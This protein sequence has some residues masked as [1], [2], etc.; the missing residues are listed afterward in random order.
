M[1]RC[2]RV[3]FCF[4]W[5]WLILVPG[6]VVAENFPTLYEDPDPELQHGLVHAVNEIGLDHAIANGNLALA[7]VD[8]TDLANPKVA[9]LNGTKMMYAAS[10]P[11]IVILFGLFKRVEEGSITYE[12]SVKSMAEQM[13]RYSS[14]WAATELFDLVQPEFLA[15]LLV[16]PK[17]Q[18]YDPAHGGGLWVGK[19]Y[20]KASAWRREPLQ[21]L[22]HAAT[23]LQT[24]RFYYLLL[25]DQLVAKELR[26][27]MES[28]LDSPGLEH[29]FVLGMKQYCPKAKLLRKS[30]SWE[31]FHSDS[32]VI[33]HNGKR[34]IA[35]GLTH[36]SNGTAWLEKLIPRLD[37][38]I[39]HVS[40]PQMG[41]NNGFF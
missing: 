34:Y 36:H 31:A 30:G 41:C 16:S 19:E 24:A 23:A 38:V 10:L 8:V 40:E 21:N 7:L 4:Y 28:A 15:N 27:L 12:G 13:I 14:N 32:A 20:S 9:S 39:F 2:K 22:T 5:L 11:K 18:L 25:T 3:L 29:K 6:I 33:S 26:P 35:V 1:M 17:Y 37:E